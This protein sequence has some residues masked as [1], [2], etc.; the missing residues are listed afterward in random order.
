MCMILKASIC[1]NNSRLSA[2]SMHLKIF[3]SFPCLGSARHKLYLRP[4]GRLSLLRRRR[5]SKIE[6]WAVSPYLWIE[7][8]SSQR[9]MKNYATMPYIFTNIYPSIFPSS[10]SLWSLVDPCHWRSYLRACLWN[11]ERYQRYYW[12]CPE[13]RFRQLLWFCSKDQTF[14]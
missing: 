4:P 14:W 2:D 3:A 12:T 11:I 7:K 5:E 13:N 10:K 1:S 6:Y 9:F 8:K